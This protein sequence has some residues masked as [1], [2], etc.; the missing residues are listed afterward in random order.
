VPDPAG[1][2]TLCLFGSFEVR[3]G[4][5]PLPPPRSRK[6]QWLLALLALR[7]GHD[8]ERDWLVETLWPGTAPAQ[9]RHS[10]SMSLTDLRRVLGPD[11]RRLRSR[12]RHSLCLDLAN[13]AVDLIAFDAAVAR[14]DAAS[15]AGAVALYRGPLLEGW[16]EEWAFTERQVR[17][18]AYLSALETLAAQSRAGGDLGETERHLRCVVAVDPL[19]ETAQRELM[20][21][22]A[23]GGNYAAAAQVYHDLRLR[24]QREVN[25]DPDPGTTALFERLR[26]EARVTGVGTPRAQ[27]DASLE[28]RQS[29]L[30]APLTS[31]IGRQWEVDTIRELLRQGSLR[32]LTLTGPGGTGKTRLAFQVT[33]DLLDE[34]GDGVFF[35]DL[36]SIQDPEL[37]ATTIAQT[38]G[39]QESGDQPPLD[40]LNA[41]LRERQLLLLLDNFEQVL[42]AAPLVAELLQAAPELK[43]LVTSREA[44]HVRGEQ[45]FPVPPLSVPP[46][47]ESRGLS[48]E[49]PRM[50]GSPELPT[51]KAQFSTLIQYG[52]VA[53]FVQRAAQAKPEFALTEANAAAVAEICRR[54]DGLPLALELAA[55]RVKLFAP[56]AL[57]A[58]LQNRLQLL[59]NGSRDAPARQQTLRDAITW[60]YDLLEER[61][62][63]LFRR[64]SIFVGGCT[65]DAAEAVCDDY[66]LRIADCSLPT[67]VP[68]IS[69]GQS[70][71]RNEEVLNSAASLADK[72]LLRHGETTDGEPRFRMLET[73]REYGLECLAASGELELLQRCHAEFFVALAEEAE[74]RFFGRERPVWLARLEADHDNLRAAFDWCQAADSPLALRLAGALAW[75]WNFGGH[76]KEGWQR[77]RAVLDVPTEDMTLRAR[78]LWA[79]GAMSWIRGDL[80]LGRSH[81]EASVGLW[82]EVGDAQGLGRA[83]RELGNV[84]WLGGDLPGALRVHEESAR[85]FREAGNEWDLALTLYPMGFECAAA[86]DESGARASFEES[87]ALFRKLG[88]EWGRAIALV[89][90]GVVLGRRC[91]YTM[92]HAHLEEALAILREEREPWNTADVLNLLGEVAQRQEEFERAVGLYAESL[93]LFAGVGDRAGAAT[94]LYNLG[95]VAHLRAQSGRAARLF[96]AAQ[97]AGGPGLRV[98]FGALT[99]PTDRQEDKSAVHAV[100][101][102]EVFAAAWAEGQAVSPEQAIAEALKES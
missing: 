24:M 48:A 71:V 25:T 72:S 12:T 79:V 98:R 73:I 32:L 69:H 74:P 42:S 85:V 86:D 81:L 88:D 92:A 10:L 95:S 80:S 54:L 29:N 31:L 75:F 5:T 77:V 53:L 64:L 61:E 47:V 56:E 66:G 55:A 51:L 97:A 35:V 50:R 90:L 91:E 39:L 4:S 11:A 100:L 1:P 2:L 40:R 49:S 28:V 46:L 14:G 68:A 58:R 76:L 70:A 93:A 26:Q 23:G 8:V 7:H 84:L 82:R 37:V 27:T 101:G 65:L 22:L 19:R 62:K 57:L 45:E 44:L 20:Q 15:L 30:P 59:T 83:L 102:E 99:S 41:Y 21:V 33:A 67:V 38:L 16:A 94:V 9:G 18:E 36:A 43:V 78:A 87:E 52:A 6:G 60:S 89:G 96:G 3:R 13:V 34:F 63:Q 17:E